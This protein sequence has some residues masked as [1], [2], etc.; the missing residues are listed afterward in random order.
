MNLLLQSLTDNSGLASVDNLLIENDM[1]F[2]KLWIK[3]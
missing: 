1:I 3:I 2:R